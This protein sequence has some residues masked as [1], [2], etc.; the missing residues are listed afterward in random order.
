MTNVAVRPDPFAL[1]EEERSVRDTAG[2]FA[3]R[4]LA[5]TVAQRDEE[6]RYDRG[7]FNRMGE[8]GLTAIPYP[9]A[10]G[11]AG[12]SYF[13]W[14][15]ACEEIAAVDMGM[16]VSLSVHVLSQLCIF[17]FGTDD[18]KERFLPPMAAGTHLGAFALTEPQSGSDAAALALRA[19]RTDDGYQLT[20]TKVWIT[21]AGEADVYVVFATVDRS[22]G[23]EGVTAFVVE[24]D[25]SGFR[26]GSHERKM[27]IRDSSS[28]EL[29]FDHAVVPI[30]SRL[31]EEGQGLKVALDSLGAGR[32][33]IAAACTG[34]AR[35]ALEHAARYAIQRTQFGKPIAEQEM[36]QSML[37]DAAVSVEAARLLTWRAARLRDA[38][39]SVHGAGSMA[40]LYASDVAMRVAT[41]AVQIYGGAGYSRDNPVERFMRDAKG[42][43]IYEGTNQVQRLIIAQQLI[44]ELRRS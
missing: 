26:I 1:G 36:I 32:I 24:R 22:R 37:A 33:S 21:N 16:A 41:D 19:E 23:R 14:V 38:G 25:T 20:G 8:L 42:A 27:G 39:K 7:L 17:T 2:E 5:P 44:A 3:Q 4:E 15:L 29:V 31:G 10:Y 9:E 30:E 40:K 18:Q 11:G 34:L 28:A 35:A 13:A 6:E 43:Q 12:L